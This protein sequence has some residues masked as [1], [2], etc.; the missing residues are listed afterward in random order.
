MY[1][2]VYKYRD[3]GMYISISAVNKNVWALDFINIC[4]FQQKAKIGLFDSAVIWVW[5][6]WGVNC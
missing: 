1:V 2:R 6:L 3:I 5:F 4:C